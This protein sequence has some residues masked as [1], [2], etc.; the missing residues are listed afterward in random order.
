LSWLE[1]EVVVREA[2]GFVG[3]FEMDEVGVCR[4]L[5]T[6][7]QFVLSG[8]GD[9]YVRPDG[10]SPEVFDSSEEMAVGWKAIMSQR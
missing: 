3:D 9:V 6:Y 10:V 2:G 8:R 5:E 1:V 7:T 4:R